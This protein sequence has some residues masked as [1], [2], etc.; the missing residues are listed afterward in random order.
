MKVLY[1]YTEL[2]GYNLPIFERLV[3]EYGATVE[4]IHWSQNKLTPFIPSEHTDSSK[5]TFHDRSALSSSDMV[6]F[7]V[8]LAPDLVYVTG[9]M[10][11]GYFPVL[12]KLKSMGALIVA[13]LDSQWTGSLRQKIGS[14]LIRWVYKKRY[15]SYV[16]VPG[17][18]QYEY[19]ARIGFK[20]SEIICNLLSGNSD[21]FRQA[22]Q[23]LDKDKL[24]DYP[25]NFLYVGRFAQAKGIDILITAFDI[26]KEK[27]QGTWGLTCIGNGPMLDYLTDAKQRHGDLKIESFLTQPELM[28]RAKFAG[29]FVLPSRYE[30]WGVVAHEFSTAGLPLIFSECVGARSQFLIDQLNG[31]TF[32]GE[33]PEDLAY[34]MCLMSSHSNEEL[35][36]MGRMSAQLASQITPTITTASLMS[37]MSPKLVSG[38]PSKMK[39]RTS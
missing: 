14:M 26:Y 2:L 16:W 24:T 4:V 3:N 9:W 23:A 37:V 11:K 27:Y 32:Y 34:K 12:R 36:A 33:S 22:T 5:I 13:G 38:I 7:A 31:F 18:L 30:P 21:L 29:A 17:P 19:A 15:Y 6:D 39:I 35:L 25:Q 20:K 28:A 10:D 8:K 1:L